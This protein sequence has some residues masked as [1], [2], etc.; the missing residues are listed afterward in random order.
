MENIKDILIRRDD[1]S[2]EDA[3]ELIEMTKDEIR[4]AI[5][6]GD[7]MLVEHII[8]SNLGLELD[9]LWQLI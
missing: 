8:A 6:I 9:Y 1:M 4:Y 3:D 2:S 5:S 7:H